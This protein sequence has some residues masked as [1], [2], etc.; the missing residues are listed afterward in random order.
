MIQKLAEKP[1]AELA[2]STLPPRIAE[3]IY[4]IAS[5]RREGLFGIREIRI[6]RGGA[7]TVRLGREDIR[8]FS[9]VGS[10]EM[11]YIVDRLT[12][13]ALYAHRDS[14]AE[15]F[16]SL[17]R[18]IR[19]G[20]CGSAA[21]DGEGLVGISEMS[22]LVFR[23]PTGECEFAEELYGIFCSGVRRGM[24]IYS[25]PGV[26]KTTAIRSLAMR[27]GSGKHPRRVAVIDERCELDELD[28][29]GCEVDILR[30]YKKQTGIEIATRT[31]SPDLIMIDEIGVDDAKAI[32]GAL[33]CGIPFVAT[34]HARTRDELL[35]KPALKKLFDC[36]VFDRI[37]GISLYEGE[38]IL[39]AEEI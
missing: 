4:R 29:L 17:P 24:I 33:Q 26:G 12:R 27:L 32:L 9:A 39:R 38:Y 30:G 18:G 7:C 2:L 31:M 19:V 21:Y 5:G 25:P 6:R 35:S 34:A 20:I 22:S 14:I 11:E 3:E 15:G 28:Y 23:I 10:A 16:I 13:G 1:R 37:V 36:S 8:L